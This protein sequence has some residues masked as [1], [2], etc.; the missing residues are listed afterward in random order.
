MTEFSAFLQLGF[1]HIVDIAAYDHLLFIVTLSA[2]YQP[3]DWKKLLVLITAFTVGHSLTLV[4]SG[5]N[6]LRVPAELVELLIPITILLT[7]LHNVWAK[8]AEGPVFSRAIS[9]NYLLAL[10]FG[11]IHGM[12]F[13]NY[14]RTLMGETGNVAAMLFPF[15]LGIELGQ[16]VIVLVFFGVLSL[17][18]RIFTIPSRDWTVFMSGIGAGGALTMLLN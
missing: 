6:I 8:K 5:F 3:A 12:G 14:F 1:Q 17:L 18:V 13:A 10:F 11:L 15:N 9:G 7:S 2:I 4:L 16:I